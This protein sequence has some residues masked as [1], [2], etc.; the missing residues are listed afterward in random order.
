MFVVAKR[1]L[2]RAASCSCAR[3]LRLRVGAGRHARRRRTGIEDWLA[4][5][6]RK[7]RAQFGTVLG[8]PV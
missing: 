8:S 2:V 6:A 4:E 7:G 3:A 5:I 1:L